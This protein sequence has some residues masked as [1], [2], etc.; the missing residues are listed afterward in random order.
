MEQ[1][2]EAETG[3]NSKPHDKI[4]LKALSRSMDPQTAIVGEIAFRKVCSRF[5][6]GIAVATVLGAEE[7]PLGITVN[8]FTSVSCAPPLI[9]VCIDHRS[10]ILTHFRSSSFFGI[11]ILSA[12]QR[13][14]S[15]RF[16]SKDA[17]R[18][19]G[20]LFRPGVTGVPILPEALANM[21][22]SVTQVVEAGDHAIFIAEVVAATCREGDPL[23]YFGSSYQTLNPA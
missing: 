18:D 21:E 5:A 8:S 7:R 13:D 17:D 9:L 11:N 14:L 4:R 23:V 1:K 15:I 10:S 3:D 20:D 16:A 19:P 2:L 12:D 22:C 6:T